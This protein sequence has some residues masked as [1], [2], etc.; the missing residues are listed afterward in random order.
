[1]KI[2]AKAL[3]KNSAGR[4]LVLRRSVSH[5]LYPNH[6]DFPGGEVENTESGMDGVIREIAEETS[7][8]IREDNVHLLFRE[9]EPTGK[10]YVT[11]SATLDTHSPEIKLSW[12]HDK[13][14]WMT[15]SVLLDQPFP[16]GV[17]DYY[18]MV[19]ANLRKTR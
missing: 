7:L 2:V 3:I 17:D 10:V 18:E 16:E 4:I 19:I 1:M 14:D 13:Y 12:E 6:L 5:P 15:E 8:K 11:Y 9:E